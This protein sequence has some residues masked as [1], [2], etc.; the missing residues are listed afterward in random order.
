MLNIRV[1]DSGQITIPPSITA[2]LGIVRG[3][4]FSLIKRDNYY[5]MMP[6]AL[7]PLQALQT[8]M[9]GEAEKVGWE[10]E[11]DVIEYMKEVR[12]EFVAE[13]YNIK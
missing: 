8:I 10:S 6:L 13:R 7:D 1:N 5:I 9:E 12:K 4:E 3:E 11:D 2:E